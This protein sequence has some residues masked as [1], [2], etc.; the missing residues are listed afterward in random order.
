MKNTQCKA[1]IL[2]VLLGLFGAGHCLAQ[3]ADF[4]NSVAIGA[5]AIRFNTS[6]GDLNGP[7]TPPGVQVDLKNTSTLAFTYAYRLSGPW[8]LVFQAGVPPTIKIDAAG[9]ASALGEAGSGKAWFPGLLLT[10]TYRDLGFVR[11]YAGLGVNYTFFTDRKITSA[12]TSA[13]YGTGSS[14]KMKDSVGPIIKLGVEI[15]F[16]ERWH[17]DL[18]YARYWIKTEASI[19]TESPILGGSYTRKI[20]VKADPDVFALMVGYRF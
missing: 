14:A 12:Y 16:S 17:L 3:Q 7:F 15:P 11:P 13:F 19:T 2:G 6:S 10:Y 18:S 20:D 8:S 5:A 1:H 4:D 9:T